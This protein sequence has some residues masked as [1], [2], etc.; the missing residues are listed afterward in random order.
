M[1][2]SL[3]PFPTLTLSYVMLSKSSLPTE[4]VKLNTI[5]A[6]SVCHRLVAKANFPQLENNHQ[7]K[8]GK[9]INLCSV[10]FPR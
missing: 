1:H 4:E 9:E 10:Y 7:T 2:L 6:T 8:G 5:H 3:C